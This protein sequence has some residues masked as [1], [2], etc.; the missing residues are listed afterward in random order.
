[1]Y[2]SAKRVYFKECVFT[3]N[4]NVYEPAEDSFLFGENLQVKA[5]TRVLDMGTG[6]GILGILAAKVARVVAV[7][8]NPYAVRCAKGNARLNN[9]SGKISFI[10]GDLFTGLIDTPSFDVILFNAPYLP[11]GN[12]VQNSWIRYAWAGGTIGRQVID[13]FISEVQRH[14]KPEG[15]VLM[16]QSNLAKIEETI[17]RFKEYNL[18]AKV[19]VEQKLP[20][21]EKL[22]MIKAMR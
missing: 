18:K 9:V 1:M 15:H 5:G 2:S 16:M 12:S 7:D 13:R 20:F 6:C 10:Q 14:L 8:L 11:T 3:V 17:F 21:F 19:M 4:K 22:F